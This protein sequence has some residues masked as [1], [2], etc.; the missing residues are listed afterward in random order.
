MRQKMKKTILM[1]AFVLALSMGGN[2]VLAQCKTVIWPEV[3]ELKAKAE[4]NKVLYED[5]LKSGQVKHAEIPLNWL[6]TNVP[7]LHSSLYING[8][9]VFDKLASQEK[10]AVR[11]QV[12]VDS[13][14]IIYDL[15]IKICGEEATVT[16]RKALSF[17]KFNLQTK[18]AE[19]LAIL[20]KTFE[21]NGNNIMDGTLVPY[22]Q[23]VRVNK[24]KLNNLTDD[25]IME[26][27]DRVMNVIDAKIKKTQSE[28]KPVDKYKKMKDD[29]D[30]IL[31]SIVTV[32]CAF[33]KKNLEPKF[34]QTPDDLSLAKKIFTFMLQGKCTDDPLWLEA[35]EAIHKLTPVPERD[36]GL[37][38]NL[39]IKYLSK[40][41]FDKAEELL[42]EAQTIC[43]DGKDK[44]EVLIYL[45]NIEAKKGNKVAARDLF[46][47][48]A[49]A[50]PANAKEAYEKIGDLY[51]NSFGDCAKKVN[52]A[53]DRLVYLA[54]A[55]YYQRSGNG[56]KIAMAKEAFPSK[57]DIFLVNYKV[58]E[59]KTV[60]C[61]IGES[62][63]IKTRD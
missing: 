37:A 26:R 45:G 53:D 61:W 7:N 54:A 13:L 24:G 5:A 57:E 25:Q 51:Y 35:G 16:N 8:A 62:V 30:A 44:A 39:G 38:K 60:G 14:M 12:Y 4:E 49:S 46:R 10:D 28:G 21:L 58:G 63:T 11:K 48:S 32:D 3:P 23:T 6:L 27:Y 15:R 43:T 19:A 42:K 40:E 33:V 55:E 29:I 20:D 47:Q 56:K 2:T 34:K 17:V 50:D 36:C 41:N 18:P 59:T 52:Q 1:A 31:I 22:M 9:E